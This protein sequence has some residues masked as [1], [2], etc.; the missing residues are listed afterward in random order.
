M[1]V[2]SCNTMQRLELPAFLW[3]WQRTKQVPVVA[4]DI[5]KLQSIEHDECTSRVLACMD[6]CCF[7]KRR[8][9]VPPVITC[10]RCLDRIV[11]LSLFF[12]FIGGYSTIVLVLGVCRKILRYSSGSPTFLEQTCGRFS[13]F[14][15]N[16]GCEMPISFSFWSL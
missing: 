2:E 5:L 1:G 10:L 12:G 14:W 13:S 6:G 15:M 11:S 8:R 4:S 3:G 9:G 16:E 7:H